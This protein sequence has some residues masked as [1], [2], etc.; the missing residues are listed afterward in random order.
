MYGKCIVQDYGNLPKDKCLKEFMKPKEC[1]LRAVSWFGF[2][3]VFFFP[4]PP[5]GCRNCRISQWIYMQYLYLY[6]SSNQVFSFF[7]F[8]PGYTIDE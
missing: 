5:G 8:A 7:F 3:L 1:V 6:L 4:P 2:G